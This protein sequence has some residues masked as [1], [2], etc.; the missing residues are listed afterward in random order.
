MTGELFLGGAFFIGL[1]L[2]LALLLYEWKQKG[3]Q[4]KYYVLLTRG[5]GVLLT[6]SLA[7][8][9]Y[10]FLKKD[11]NLFYVFSKVSL[12]TPLIYRLSAVWIGQ[13]GV[14]LVWAWA[15]SMC[16]L[17]FAEKSKFRESFD[18]KVVFTALLLCTLFMGL[19]MM[20]EPFKST[21]SALRD[22]AL[23][24]GVSFDNLLFDLQATGFYLADQGFIQGRGMS[25]VLMSPW[26]ALHPPVVFIAYA[27]ASIP[28]GICL[29][30]LFGGYG[31]GVWEKKSLQWARL[32]WIFLGSGLLIGSF[33]AYE[34][35]SFGSYWTWDPIETAS[36]IP[37]FTLTV[38]LHGSHEHRRKGTFGIITP[39]F[40][41]LTTILII[42]G[43]F[44]TKSGLVESSHAYEKSAITPFLIAALVLFTLALIFAA[45]K[46]YF[47]NRNVKRTWRPFIS[48]SNTFYISA[49]F[50]F[51]LIAV[52]MG[53]L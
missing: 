14:F 19:A 42:Y 36:L 20:M 30:Y 24:R 1:L 22:D 13:E 53:F 49:I 21:S 9:F 2:S 11:F 12:E 32:S 48:I 3:L 16:L 31:D 27:L 26:M 8:L 7:L 44:I 43:T 45:A 52:L 46:T 29:V 4:Q 35:L 47:K 25:P 33:W 17:L 6:V 23:M 28:F 51:L 50:F 18:R 38:F 5:L 15:I 41:V 10:S 37:W 39:V 40:G 34:E